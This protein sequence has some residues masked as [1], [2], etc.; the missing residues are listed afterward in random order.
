MWIKTNESHAHGT[1]QLTG[2]TAGV[3]LRLLCSSACGPYL[4]RVPSAE[5]RQ[6]RRQPRFRRRPS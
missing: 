3:L 4:G 2:S 1:F 5:R 6:G